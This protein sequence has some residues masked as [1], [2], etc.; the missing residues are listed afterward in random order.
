[1]MKSRGPETEH[2][3]TPQ[4]EACKDEILLPHLTSKKISTAA[5]L[6]LIEN[7]VINTDPR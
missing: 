1:M 2:W 7:R 4:E 3:G 6:E 5:K